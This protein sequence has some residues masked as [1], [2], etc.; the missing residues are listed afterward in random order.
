MGEA[1]PGLDPVFVTNVFV[2]N[3]DTSENVVND[4]GK[5]KQSSLTGRLAGRFLVQSS[6]DPGRQAQRHQ[7]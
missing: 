2:T 5:S 1:H 7:W 6:S 4:R 3:S